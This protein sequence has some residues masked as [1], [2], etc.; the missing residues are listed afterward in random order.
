VSEGKSVT[1]TPPVQSPYKTF[2]SATDAPAAF[3]QSGQQFLIDGAG[4]DLFNGS[5]AYSSIYDSGSVGTTSTVTTKVTAE[6]GLTGFAKA[7]IIVRNDMTGS[8]TTPEGVTLLTSPSGG[9]QL[10]WNDNGGTYIDSVTPPNGTSPGIAPVWLQLQRSGSTY[11]G[12]YSF[13]GST[14]LQAGSATVPGQADTQDAGMFVTSH[15]AGTPGQATFDGFAVSGGATAP[16]LASVYVAAA[17]GNTI[18]GGAKV[19]TCPSCYSGQKV[20]FVGEGGTVTF[21]SVTV[22]TAGTYQVEIGYLDG[23]GR[24]ADVTVNGGTPQS[25]QFTSTG[26][27]DNMGFQTVP[28]QLSAGA[29]T[30]E[31]SNPSAFAPDFNA[32]IIPASP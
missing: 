8:G 4:A 11:T 17:A 19:A 2:S 24:Q 30:I 21:N 32:L 18:A 20:G 22:P 9:I 6:Q 16:P 7:G 28:M 25:V 26:S 29:N 12:Y 10:E 23:S 15:S 5:D 1:V 31:L 13:D 14:W 27:F 3:G